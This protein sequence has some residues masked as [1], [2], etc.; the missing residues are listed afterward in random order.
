MNSTDKKFK[1][2][3]DTFFL[4]AVLFG[5]FYFFNQRSEAPKKIVQPVSS[6]ELILSAS[7]GSI[8]ENNLLKGFRVIP[9]DLP[10]LNATILVLENA[11]YALDNA[12][13]FG[14]IIKPLLKHVLY[15]QR[16]AGGL[17][18]FPLAA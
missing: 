13:D 7:V 14:N 9:I 4:C 17:D 15:L 1:N 10:N 6:T 12:S 11:R 5:F 16:F 2:L 8:V 18:G 3:R